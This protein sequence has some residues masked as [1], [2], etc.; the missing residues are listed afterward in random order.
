MTWL[1]THLMTLGICASFGAFAAANSSP[2]DGY[3]KTIDDTTAYP[4]ALVQIY[5]E[6]NVT[7]GKVLGGYPI[8]GVIPHETCPE[9]PPPFKDQPVTGMRIVWDMQYNSADG[10]FEG[11]RILDPESGHIYKARLTPGMDNQ[12][13]H[14]RGYI[15]IPLI[16]RTQSWYRV[17]PAQYT[18]FMQEQAADDKRVKLLSQS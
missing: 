3:W 11:G 14:V 9:C 17:T 1:K 2:I 8:N 5:T 15:G 13:L 4:K 16:G 7:Y 18:D 12:V 10:A 6:N